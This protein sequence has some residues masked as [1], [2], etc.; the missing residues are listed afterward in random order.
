M[1]TTFHWFSL[2]LPRHFL[3]ITKADLLPALNQFYFELHKDELPTNNTH[4]SPIQLI[5][6]EKILTYSVWTT[7]DNFSQ[8]MKKTMESFFPCKRYNV[9]VAVAPLRKQPRHPSEQISQLLYNEAFYGFFEVENFVLGYGEDGYWGY[10]SK[11]QLQPAITLPFPITSPRIWLPSLHYPVG[12]RY[13]VPENYLHPSLDEVL[14]AYMGAPYLWGGRSNW[15]IDCS[16]LTQMVYEF[17]HLPLP[18]DAYLQAE[19][20]KIVTWENRAPLNLAF[21]GN[22]QKP[23]HVGILIDK[24]TILHAYGAVRTDTL[25]QK[26][27]FNPDYNAYTHS[28]VCI[29]NYF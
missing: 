27:I 9:N 24:H 5:E 14:N 12:S 2:D 18:R 22:P 13:P 28:L 7:W 17:L 1:A 21:F 15:G 29:K 10:I 25:T 3:Y 8:L 20:G 4:S 11:H 26:G 6:T 19:L 23:S 16:G